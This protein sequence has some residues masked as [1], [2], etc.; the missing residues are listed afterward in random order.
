MF[1]GTVPNLQACNY[2]VL[3]HMFEVAVLVALQTLQIALVVVY[4]NVTYCPMK[5]TTLMSAW[6]QCNVF[7]PNQIRR[8]PLSM[9][10]GCGM[11]CSTTS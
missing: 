7:C 10:Y 4:S 5:F 8:R 3:M 9:S 6:A 11:D 1:I 2:H